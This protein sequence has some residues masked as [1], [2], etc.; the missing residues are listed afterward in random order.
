MKN[1][2]IKE[3]YLLFLI[4]MG[5]ISLS[6]YSTYALFTASTTINNVV[7]I[8]ASLTTNSAILEYEM[9]EVPAGTTKIIEVTVKNSYSQTLYYGAW[10]E[11]LDGRTADFSMGLYTEKDNTGNTGQ[12]SAGGS[13]TLLVGIRNCGDA[14][15]L[16][17]VGTVGS[18][19][20]SLGLS[21]PRT[22]IPTGWIN[23]GCSSPEKTLA[24]LGLESSLKTGT[25]DFSKISP[26][27]TYTQNIANNQTVSLT[28]STNTIRLGS[29]ISF[30]SSTGKFTLGSTIANQT[31]GTSAVGKYTCAS[32]SSTCTKAYKIVSATN[33]GI[34][35]DDDR[36]TVEPACDVE[37]G[38]AIAFGSTIVASGT[39]Y[40][41]SGTILFYDAVDL[42]DN[43]D[44]V[45]GYW[46]CCGDSSCTASNIFKVE[47][48]EPT[49]SESGTVWGIYPRD[50]VV[51]TASVTKA[52][53]YTSTSSKNTA[54]IGLF[55]STDNLANSYY[56]RGDVTNNYVSFAGKYW[57]I[58]RING[59]GSIRMIYD[60][61][62]AY[63]NGIS[64]SNRRATTS[65]YANYY[66]STSNLVYSSNLIPNVLN[67]WYNSNLRNYG[68]FIQTSQ[69]CS[70]EGGLYFRDDG[71]EYSNAYIRLVNSKNPTLVCPQ[72]SYITSA[73]IGLI[74]A[75]EISMAGGVYG[76]TNN[77]FYLYMGTS[78]YTMTPYGF[79]MTGASEELR[80]KIF[81][82]G[83]YLDTEETDSSIGIRPVISLKPDAITGG[84]GTK[85]NPFVVDQGE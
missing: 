48:Y 80:A 8:T 65:A 10:Y 76:T 2:K 24:S 34:S 9:M 82:Y 72:N 52:N 38:N 45:N 4:V 19:T 30:N 55:A 57:R 47:Y 51:G 61:T 85:T 28:D 56:F 32:S 75:D 16:L 81:A 42:Y 41:L 26:L 66:D 64:N 71:E 20:S 83:S 79:E 63:N 46:S 17:N 67:T 78:F 59:D 35:W 7:G 6:V 3:T 13:A 1:I 39:G 68:D 62:S 22:L 70:D 43:P 50:L 18:T 5:L 69:F 40:K 49:G 77:A 44:L 15:L 60:G 12:I 27:T 74:T 33:G 14:P 21:S 31:Y 11:I 53:V 84:A 54:D 58:I 36:D 25:P 37:Y 29:T 73:K 23:E